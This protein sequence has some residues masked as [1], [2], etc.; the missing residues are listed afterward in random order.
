LIV[1]TG[2]RQT[3]GRAAAIAQTRSDECRVNVTSD[4]R[5]KFGK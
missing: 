2:M 1:R 3:L 4:S 5:G